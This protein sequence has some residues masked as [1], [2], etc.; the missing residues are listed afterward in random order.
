MSTSAKGGWAASGGG[1]GASMEYVSTRGGTGTVDFEGA[2]FSGYAPDQ[3]L[4]MPQHIPLLD[5]DTL[6]RWSSLS[7]RELV[8]ELC[9]LFITAEL[10][11]RSMLNDLI[12][13]AFSRFRHKDVVHLSRLKD[14]L[15]VLELWHGVTYAFKDLSL[16]CTG[17]FLQ[18]FLEKKQKHVTILVGTSGDTGSSAIESVRGQ[19]NMDI[20]VLLPK[21]FCTQIQELQMTTVIEDN[22]H[23]FAAHGN[24]DEIDEPIKELFADV[25]FARKYN[26]MSL[27][28]VNWSRIMVQIAH[29]FYA[30]FQCAPSLDTTP[31]PVVEIVVPTGGGG[32]ITAGCIAQKMGLPIRLV[33]A[34][35][36]NDII[37]RTVQHGDFSLSESVKATLASAMDIQLSETLHSCSASDE[38]IVRAM[39]RCWE[40]NHY[41]LCP[42][43]AVA[44][45][46]HYSQPDGAPRCCLAPASAAKFQD[47]LLRAGLVPQLPP[48]ITAL[49]AM[50]TRST[51][52]DRGQDWAQAL[53]GWIEAM[54][55]WREAQRH[56]L[57]A[58]GQQGITG[59]GVTQT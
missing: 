27:N 19:K 6:R 56:C 44:A 53:R 2:L 25:D 39:Q 37:H 50:K 58:S 9:S 4:F 18:Y 3:G 32:N 45:H 47:A 12:D 23:V 29:H 41:L 22:V 5:G 40:E 21:G 28:S 10:I 46:Y 59:Q 17:Q 48:E 7:Y 8:K 13:R 20:F 26:L 16:S 49:T 57:A 38:D 51:P 55:Q 35:N 31:L 15:N 1:G 54:A 14:G 33:A 30:Y 42:H 52:L 43:S 36:S 34:V 11:P 24:S